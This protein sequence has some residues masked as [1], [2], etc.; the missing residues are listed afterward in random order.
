MQRPVS[1]RRAKR[2]LSDSFLAF[3]AAVLYNEQNTNKRME[4]NASGF[5]KAFGRLFSGESMFLNE[6]TLVRYKK[7]TP[8]I[9]FQ[10]AD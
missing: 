10:F 1:T 5:K 6:Y 2:I 3:F 7:V 8:H 4:T 9:K